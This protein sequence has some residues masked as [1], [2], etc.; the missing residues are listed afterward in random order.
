MV[1]NC[2][3]NYFHEFKFLLSMA[4]CLFSCQVVENTDK[5]CHIRKQRSVKVTR[6][7]ELNN[8]FI[9]HLSNIRDVV[10][11]ICIHDKTQENVLLLGVVMVFH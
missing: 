9:K 8:W 5:T 1:G 11:K 2:I 10:S 6:S 4:S 7:Q 3:L